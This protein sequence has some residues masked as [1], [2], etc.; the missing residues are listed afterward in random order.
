[1]LR[2][3]NIG[4]HFS[5]CLPIFA[6][7]GTHELPPTESTRQRVSIET[8]RKQVSFETTTLLWLR[9]MRSMTSKPTLFPKLFNANVSIRAL[10]QPPLPLLYMYYHGPR[11]TGSCSNPHFPLT[12]HSF[13]PNVYAKDQ[14]ME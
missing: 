2:S 1:M 10:C 3:L 7:L 4:E 8:T 12:Y 9:V 6:T 13:Q 14:M 5:E 11:Y